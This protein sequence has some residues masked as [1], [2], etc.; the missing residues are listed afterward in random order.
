LE[1]RAG[2]LVT[3]GGRFGNNGRLNA[4]PVRLV[5]LAKVILSLKVKRE[6]VEMAAVRSAIKQGLVHTRDTRSRRVWRTR[7]IGDSFPRIF[8]KVA[9]WPKIEKYQRRLANNWG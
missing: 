6:N 4:S 8:G 7:R 5:V 2:R 1:N 3:A 9:V